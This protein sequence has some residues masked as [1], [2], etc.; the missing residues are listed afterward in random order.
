MDGQFKFRPFFHDKGSKTFLGKT[1]NFD[2][3]DILK[4]LL[5]QKQT[6]LFITK[7]IYRYFVNDNPDA[8]HVQWLTERFYQSNY[9]IAGLLHDIYTAEWF[10]DDKNIGQ[11]IKSPV[12]LI[13]GIR[14]TLPMTID[15]AGIQILLQRVLGQLLFY[16]PNVAGWPGGKSWIDSS[17]LMLRLRLPQLIHGNEEFAVKPKADDD[18]Q[19]GMKENFNNIKPANKGAF[20]LNAAID[21][22][23]YINNFAPVS[24]EQLYNNIE[25]VL[26]QTKPGSVT[27]TAVM[28]LANNSTREE[29]IKT[30]TIAL[31]STPEYQL[32]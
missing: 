30:V 2:G 17:S 15:N 6:A 8:G 28:G 22:G 7:K 26:L 29:Y 32:C 25:G 1:G 4:I 12:E 16:P 21:W 14:R 13:V 24:K 11:R 31:M 23:A 19:M 20:Q 27:K 9:N 18:Q 5:E 10:Y 3:D